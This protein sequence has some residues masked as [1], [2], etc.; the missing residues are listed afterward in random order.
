MTKNYVQRIK[1]IIINV[2]GDFEKVKNRVVE[3]AILKVQI[4]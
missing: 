4:R 1:Y 2:N 3:P